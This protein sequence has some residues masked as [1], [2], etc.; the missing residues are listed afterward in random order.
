MEGSQV[1]EGERGFGQ[2]LVGYK[3]PLSV[4]PSLFVEDM[5]VHVVGCSGK[6]DQWLG[7]DIKVVAGGGGGTPTRFCVYDYMVAFW[8][9]GCEERTEDSVRLIDKVVSGGGVIE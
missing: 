5:V 8:S 1:G 3:A 7:D 4:V 9:K 6:V 2:I